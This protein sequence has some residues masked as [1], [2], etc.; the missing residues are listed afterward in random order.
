MTMLGVG[1]DSGTVRWRQDSLLGPEVNDAK[2]FDLSQHVMPALLGDSAIVLDADEAGLIAVRLADGAV[3]W[4]VPDSVIDLDKASSPL[5]VLDGT[6]YVGRQRTLFAID[7]KTGALRWKSPREFPGFVQRV[8]QSTAGLVVG[9]TF[10]HTGWTSEPRVF[11]DVVD[12]ANGS[13]RWT[14]AVEIRGVSP[15]A[16]RGDTIFQAV[17]HGFRAMEPSSGKMLVEVDA[18]EFGGNE[19]PLI[20]D[21]MENG[22]FMLVSAQNLM[23]VEPTGRV[24]YHR[25]LKAPGASKLAKLAAVTATVAIG[26][27]TGMSSGVYYVPTGLATAVLTA[28]FSSTVNANKYAYIYTGQ[29]L[30][31][32]GGFDLVRFDKADG[33]EKGRVRLTDRSPTYVIEPE[34]G[35]VATI[36][37]RELVAYRYPRFEERTS[38]K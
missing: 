25:Y 30:E 21:P 37:G 20:V 12:P 28:R 13:S 24:K 3:L 7:T 26:A 32:D 17:S 15:F 36:V 34:T 35:T 11:V 31:G 1:I 8:A 2:P 18:L 5:S 38:S 16:V 6:L 4:R 29:I 22:D 14:K 10:L 27:L 19:E 23:R 9:G 33:S